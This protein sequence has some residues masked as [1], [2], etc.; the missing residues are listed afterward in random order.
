MKQTQKHK[1][2]SNHMFEKYLPN[3]NYCSV[4]NTIVW[5]N[6]ALVS[7]NFTDTYCQFSH[8]LKYGYISF[9]CGREKIYFFRSV[10]TKLLK[11]NIRNQFIKKNMFKLICFTGII[12]VDTFLRNCWIRVTW[13][14]IFLFGKL[15]PRFAFNWF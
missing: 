2:H 3:P 1:Q 12:F 13:M 14:Q 11:V 10:D 5:Q 7:S 4:G 9:L 8:L 6:N 15:S